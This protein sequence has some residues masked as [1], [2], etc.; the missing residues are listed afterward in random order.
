MGGH[1]CQRIAPVG[2][3]TRGFAQ[4]KGAQQQR[5]TLVCLGIEHVACEALGDSGVFARDRRR[6]QVEQ[7]GQQ[8][9]VLRGRRRWRWWS[10]G[11]RRGRSRSPS[12]RGLGRG[13]GCGRG[14]GGRRRGCR[15]VDDAQQLVDERRIIVRRP[16]AVRQRDPDRAGLRLRVPCRFH[17]ELHVIHRGLA[18]DGR[19]RRGGFHCVRSLLTRR[20]HA[21][22]QEIAGDFAGDRELLGL[23]QHRRLLDDGGRCRRCRDIRSEGGP[24]DQP[25]QHRDKTDEHENP[26]GPT[27]HETGIGS[28]RWRLEG[29]NESVRRSLA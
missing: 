4:G 22:A 11:R 1:A 12:R 14:C 9:G 25:G 23:R 7:R 17:P 3:S 27:A 21:H 8:R 20:I 24:S 2:E 13:R 16:E 19:D 5:G 18:L 10:R 26:P 6:L 28:A 29:E 15:R